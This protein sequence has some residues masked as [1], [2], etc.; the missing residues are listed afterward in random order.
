MSEQPEAFQLAAE[1]ERTDSPLRRPDTVALRAAELL[2]QQWRDIEHAWAV[3][4]E[5][6]I[7]HT[8]AVGEKVLLIREQHAEIERLRAEVGRLEAELLTKQ[9]GQYVDGLFGRRGGRS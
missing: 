6:A 1:L 7:E 2:R 5:R 8:H 4:R 9:R 3:E